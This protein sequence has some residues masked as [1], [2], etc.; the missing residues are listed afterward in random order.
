MDRPPD[1]KTEYILMQSMPYECADEGRKGTH[2]S[3]GILH[4]G[5]VV[6][7]RNDSPGSGSQERVS[8]YVDG[9]GIVSLEQRFIKRVE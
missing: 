6:L 5:R 3:K 1:F 8:V 2:A 7:L 9:I 4:T